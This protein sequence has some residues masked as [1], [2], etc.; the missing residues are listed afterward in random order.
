MRRASISALADTI[1]TQR[2]CWNARRSAPKLSTGLEAQPWKR[3]RGKP[4]K[5]LNDVYIEDAEKRLNVNGLSVDCMKWLAADRKDEG[6]LPAE[7]V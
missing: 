1:A 3:S 5:I 6:M 7:A 2:L 4:R